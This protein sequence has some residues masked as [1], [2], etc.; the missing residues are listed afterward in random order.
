MNLAIQSSGASLLESANFQAAI[1]PLSLPNAGYVY[2]DKTLLQTL[3]QRFP[4]LQGVQQIGN[5]GLS[6][7]FDRLQSLAMTSYGRTSQEDKGAVS[8]Q[9]MEKP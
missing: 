6:H 2:L 3:P 7:L 8:I 1:A 5:T 9:F 4:N